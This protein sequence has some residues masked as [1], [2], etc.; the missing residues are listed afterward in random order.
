[1]IA[2][3]QRRIV[4][5]CWLLGVGTAAG[6]RRDVA[7]EARIGI[8]NDRHART[9]GDAT[10]VVGRVGVADI[11][12]QIVAVAGGGSGRHDVAARQIGLWRAVGADALDPA[13]GKRQ[14]AIL[15]R[16]R[17]LLGNRCRAQRFLP[18]A[19]GGRITPEADDLRE[20]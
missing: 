15:G 16:G 2:R 13:A 6:V 10:A 14:Q 4:L 8:G 17:L 12:S 9:L 1:K 5:L 7:G 19:V 3:R 20:E 11:G 18:G